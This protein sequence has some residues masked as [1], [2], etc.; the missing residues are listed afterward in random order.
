MGQAKIVVGVVHSQL[1]ADAI[2]TLTQRGDTSP[3]CRHMLADG[4]VDALHKRG[5]DLLAAWC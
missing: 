3:D 1:L 2:L 4:E 5:I